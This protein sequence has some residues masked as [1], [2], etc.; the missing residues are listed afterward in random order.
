MVEQADARVVKLV[1]ELDQERQRRVKAEQ[2]ARGLHAAFA[3]LKAQ[4]T[5]DAKPTKQRPRS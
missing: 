4:R 3:K 1:R 5:A 2:Q